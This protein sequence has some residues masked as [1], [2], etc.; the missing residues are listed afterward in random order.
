VQTFDKTQTF[1]PDTVAPSQT[2]Y[3]ILYP[4]SD[5]EEVIRLLDSVGVPGFT[6]TQKVVGRG[7]RGRHLDNAIWPGADGMI[8]AVVGPTHD[9]ALGSALAAYSRSL[10]ARSQGLSG[11]HV[12][13][14]PCDQ[15][16]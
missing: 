15:L 2:M 9:R 10:E 13:T 3:L 1:A 16:F 14:W 12:F 5:R 8:Y 6:E 4:E 7:R 11:M